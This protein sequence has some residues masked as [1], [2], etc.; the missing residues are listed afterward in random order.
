MGLPNVPQAVSA[1]ALRSTRGAIRSTAVIAWEFRM[2][3]SGE[4]ATGKMGV[5]DD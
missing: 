4:S 2:K 5:N 3:R 1:C